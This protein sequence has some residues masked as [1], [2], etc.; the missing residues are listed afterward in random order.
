[1]RNQHR[2]MNITRSFMFSEH[3]Q[4]CS[5][6]QQQCPPK[7]AYYFIILLYSTIIKILLFIPC[8]SVNFVTAIWVI[9]QIIIIIIIKCYY[10]LGVTLRETDL[11]SDSVA[12]FH[13]ALFRSMLSNVTWFINVRSE[14]FGT[15]M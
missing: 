12:F 5:M 2:N 9:K 6:T 8:N 7:L 13:S 1:M 15:I 10:V 3:F 14:I 4:I 11:Y